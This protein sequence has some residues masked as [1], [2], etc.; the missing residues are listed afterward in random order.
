VPPS[1]MEAC[2]R[3]RLSRIHSPR[4]ST[5]CGHSRNPE[6]GSRRRHGGEP[7]SYEVALSAVGAVCDATERL[8]RGEDTGALCIIRPPGHHALMRRAMGFCIFNNVAVAARSAIDELGLDR[9][10]IVDWDIHHGNGTQASFWRSRGSGSSQSTAGRSFPDRAGDETGAGL[11]SGD[12]ERARPLRHYA[13]RVPGGVRRR[14][15]A[16]RRQDEAATGLP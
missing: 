12:P 4:T 14:V 15:G 11:D 16:I 13:P 8:I 1:G 9:V 2:E 3:Q 7:A 6:G 10:L 5:R